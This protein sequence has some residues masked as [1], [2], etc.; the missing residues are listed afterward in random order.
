M[1]EN[2][3]EQVPVEFRFSISQPADNPYQTSEELR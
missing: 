2:W 3:K 1:I